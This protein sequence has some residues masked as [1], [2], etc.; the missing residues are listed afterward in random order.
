MAAR[1]G[2]QLNKFSDLT[3][4]FNLNSLL[5]QGDTHT[6]NLIMV[7]NNAPHQRIIHCYVSLGT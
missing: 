1:D 3:L 2:H 7:H 6:S 5:P 4:L